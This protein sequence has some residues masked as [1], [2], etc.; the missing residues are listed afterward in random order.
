MNAAATKGSQPANNALPPRC[1]DSPGAGLPPHRG[2]ALAL[3]VRGEALALSMYP[4]R[5]HHRRRGAGNSR[6]PA[7][8]DLS[9]TLAAPILGPDFGPE[10]CG[11][12][13][14]PQLLGDTL[15]PAHFGAKFRP[16]KQVRPKPLW[17]GL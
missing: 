11:P 14:V 13:G 9:G 6:A 2:Q 8:D 1:R 15:W 16:Q 3:P 5:L 17:G 12:K 10:I 4:L 7:W